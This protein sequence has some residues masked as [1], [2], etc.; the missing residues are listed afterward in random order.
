MPYLSLRMCLNCLT[1]AIK[2]SRWG[3]SWGFG[4]FCLLVITLLLLKHRILKCLTLKSCSLQVPTYC[5]HCLGEPL[6]LN[7]LFIPCSCQTNSIWLTKCCYQKNIT[8]LLRP[9]FSIQRVKGGIWEDSGF[10]RSCMFMDST[11]LKHLDEVEITWQLG[12]KTKFQPRAVPIAPKYSRSFFMACF[13]LSLLA[14]L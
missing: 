4:G 3:F 1:P 5:K 10:E 6:N 2:D 11:L 12:H 14:H 8:L 7:T 13:F 9:V